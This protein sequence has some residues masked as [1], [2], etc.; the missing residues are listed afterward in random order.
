MAQAL[1][2]VGSDDKY[3]LLTVMARGPILVDG[4]KEG[5]SI[6]PHSLPTN[7]DDKVIKVLE[8]LARKGKLGGGSS[9]SAGSGGGRNGLSKAYRDHFNSH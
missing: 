6:Q 9:G 3:R 7:V 5:L 1:H 2:Q 4:Y 8:E